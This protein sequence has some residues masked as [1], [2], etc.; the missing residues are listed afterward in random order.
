MISNLREPQPIPVVKV[1]QGWTSTI[2]LYNL[3]SRQ[4][5]CSKH[6]V[7]SRGKTKTWEMEVNE[8]ENENEPGINAAVFCATGWTTEETVLVTC[9]GRACATISVTLSWEI[10][11]T[12]L[13]HSAHK[14]LAPNARPN[15]LK[16]EDEL[17]QVRF[18][19]WQ[20]LYRD[21]VSSQ[22]FPG[23][24]G[25][26]QHQACEPHTGRFWWLRLVMDLNGLKKVFWKRFLALYATETKDMS[27]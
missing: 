21:N 23:R 3:W 6:K 4:T 8:H 14:R 20:W 15:F 17:P 13:Q 5:K 9:S 22:I 2:C 11:Q 1:V 25:C 27:W 18:S 16:L 7:Y 12:G 24:A 10:A 26:I 19:P